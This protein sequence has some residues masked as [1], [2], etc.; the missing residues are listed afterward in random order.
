MIGA[1]AGDI[2]GSEAEVFDALN[3]ADADIFENA[4]ATLG[5]SMQALTLL[6]LALALELV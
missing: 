6:A 2:I 1:I 5:V 3:T 4:R